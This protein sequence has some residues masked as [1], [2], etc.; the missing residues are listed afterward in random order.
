MKKI[1]CLLFLAISVQSMAQKSGLIYDAH[2]QKRAVPAFNAIKVS[3]AINL[4]LTQ[5]NVNEVAVSASEDDIRDQ[6]VTEVVGG[7]LIIRLGESGNWFTWKKWG[8]YQTKAYVSIKDIN[9]LSASGAS[10]VHVVGTIESQKMRIKM[11]GASDLK[12]AQLNVGTLLMEVSGASSFKANAQSSNI[13]L[14]CSGASSVELIGSA[15]DL[16]VE[17]SGASNAKLGNLNVK[18]AVV[19]SSGASD[20]AV[21]VSQL[22]KLSA[23]GAS[24][25][26]Y[27]GDAKITETN[28]SGASTIKRRNN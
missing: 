23:S 15:D 14:D 6:I 21:N 3:S 25:I 11:T 19:Q 7:T 17:C 9:A 5:S 8:N 22:M 10:N 27:T 2:A 4:Y 26:R 28:A 1:L 12:N 20:V 18:G 24:S 13:T 16:A